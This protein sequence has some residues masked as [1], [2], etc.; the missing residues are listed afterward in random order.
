LP[1]DRDIY[2]G[3]GLRLGATCLAAAT[4]LLPAGFFLGGLAPFGG[5]PGFGVLIVPVA[6]PILIFGLFAVARSLK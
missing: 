1:Y 6:A 3:P 4:V 2:D 5:D